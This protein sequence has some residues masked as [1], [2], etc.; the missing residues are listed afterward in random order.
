MDVVYPRCCGLDVHKRTVV[1]CVIVSRTRGTPH[2]EIRTFG[3]MTA[4]LLE[5]ADWLRAQEVTHVAMEST[6]VYWQPIYNL[7]EDEFTLL[8]ANARHIEAVPGRKTDV[9]DC[10]WVADLLR[11]G[12]LKASFVPQREQRELREL[13]RYRTALIRE[14]SAEVNRLQKTL[15]GANIKLAA[16]ATDVLGVSGRQMLHE[17]VAGVSDPA[18]LADLA[19]GRLREKRPQLERALAGRFGAHQRFLVAQQLAHLDDLDD[20]L[21]QLSGEIESR[22][23]PC[24]AE[25]ARLDTIPGVSQR[26][27]E[28]LL[29][30]LGADL[31]RFRSAAHLASWAG[32][33][34]GNHESAGKRHS[35]RTRQ[36]NPWLRSLLVEV[37][38]AAGRTQ[39]YLGARFRRLAAR[40]GGKKAAVAVAHKIIRIVYYLL[41]RQTVYQDL[42]VGYLDQRD[43]LAVER[44][45][46][47]RLESL[48][49]TVTLEPAV[50]AA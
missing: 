5:L 4:E 28:I 1:A 45:A 48:G 43:R 46:V 30:E 38:Q 7:L 18:V 10:E 27:A 16:V 44:R 20:I 22:L 17:L 47:R 8:L 42:G 33:C 19:R 35:G 12:L 2:K 15:E 14:R 29:A 3:T 41:T 34:P 49:Y 36:G 13:T 26:A 32:L 31:N 23:R 25:A 40:K 6:G 39:T 50:P 24:A 21:A 37:A 9:R 11:H